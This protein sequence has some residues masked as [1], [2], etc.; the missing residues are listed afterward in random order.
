MHSAKFSRREKVEALE[1]NAQ[2]IS[3]Y[4]ILHMRD[5]VEHRLPTPAVIALL[6]QVQRT[7]DWQKGVCPQW[8]TTKYPRVGWFKQAVAVQSTDG[9]RVHEE[10]LSLIRVDPPEGKAS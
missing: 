8:I 3:G 6:A 4:V 7:I 5:G 1:K 9:G 2:K 10:L